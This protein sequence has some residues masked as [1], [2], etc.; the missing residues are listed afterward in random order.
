MDSG[1]TGS[2]DKVL[3]TIDGHVFR[4]SLKRFEDSMD[5]FLKKCCEINNEIEEDPIVDV[6][7]IGVFPSD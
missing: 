3:I 2:D 5:F 1:T 4:V 6:W 7:E